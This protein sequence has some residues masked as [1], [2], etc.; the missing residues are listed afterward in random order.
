MG[1]LEVLDVVAAGR[2]DADL[3]SGVEQEVI[4]GGVVADNEEVVLRAGLRGHQW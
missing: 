1:L 4:S 3:G 2:E